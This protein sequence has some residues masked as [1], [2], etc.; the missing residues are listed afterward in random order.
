MSCGHKGHSLIIVGKDSG[1]VTVIDNHRADGV[2]YSVN[3]RYYT[4][5]GF[6]NYWG[7][8]TYIKYIKW[9]NAPVYSGADNTAPIVTK[10]RITGISPNGYYVE[11]E[12]TD[13]LSV[14]TLRIGSWNDIIGIDAAHWENQTAVNGKA[15]FS[16]SISD[17]NNAQNTAYH[18]NVYAIDGSGNVSEGVR[19]GDVILEAV[20]P[21][22]TS[23]K[24]I[25]ISK[26]GYDVVCKATDNAVLSKIQTGTWHNKMSIDDAVW[27]ECVTNG[28]E[29]I[30]HID[31]RDFNNM[32]DVTYYSNVYA[33]DRCGNVSE[34]Y[35]AGD[36]YIASVNP[37]QAPTQKPTAT[38]TPKP[39]PTPDPTAT[40]TPK[41]T[42]TP[43]PDPTATPTPDPTATPTL[44]PTVAPAPSEIKLN[45]TKATVVVGG[46][47]SLVA[48]VKPSNAKTTLKWSSSNTK[49]ATVSDSGKVKAISK[50]TATITVKTANGKKAT[51]KITVPKAPTK[52]KFK[53]ST[54]TVKKGKTIKLVPVL[55]PSG[56]KTTYKW[57]SSNK[58]IATVSSK[59]VVKGIA[60]GTA[61]I[62]VKTA[63]GKTA[64][65]KIKVK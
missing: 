50:G 23:A 11:C 51:C 41:P 13:N 43:T 2:N 16:V 9:P 63:N 58:K 26:T 47:L 65:V 34:A 17:Y 57:S 7:S 20:P 54:Y 10:A 59:G 56:A 62:T 25:N 28:E 45:K 53:K 52:V 44:T 36:T 49:V 48:K 18:T 14:Q 61:K 31:I 55:T 3:T 32:Q 42:A 38:P 12:A 19:A 21:V 29:V 39:T 6:V 15:I 24:V 27:Q 30:I 64:T 4:W 46:T 40:P 8:Y 60:K 5:Q 22:V 1:G 33:I 37:T 35:R